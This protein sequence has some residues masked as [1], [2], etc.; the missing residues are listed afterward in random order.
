MEF[1]NRAKAVRL[2]SQHNKFL[3]A[4]NDEEGVKQTRNGSSKAARWA[5]EPVEGKPNL[6]RLKSCES[7]KYLSATDEPFLLGMTGKKVL[8][9]SPRARSDP[10][11]EWEPLKDGSFVRLRTRKGHFLRANGGIPPWMNSVTHDVPSRSST[12]DWVLW[13]V[14]IL[15]VDYQSGPLVVEEDDHHGVGVNQTVVMSEVDDDQGLSRNSSYSSSSSNYGVKMERD[16]SYDQIGSPARSVKSSMENPEPSPRASPKS[17]AGVSPLMQHHLRQE[18]QHSNSFKQL[19]SMLDGI[20]N[21]LDDDNVVDTKSDVDSR[22]SS[23]DSTSRPHSLDVKMAKQILKELKNMNFS[24]IL[25]TEREKKLEKAVNILVSDAKTSTLGQ[26]PKDLI[27]LQD[28][29][30]SMKNDHESAAQDLVECTTFST[31]K[32]ETRAELKKD[33]AKAHEL[34]YMEVGFT[35]MLATSR[36]K[37]EELLRQLEEIDNSI[38]AAERAQA[39]NAVE[40]EELISRIGERSESLREMEKQEK[41]LQARKVEAE[42]TLERV[43]EEWV[44]VKSLFQDV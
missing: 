10:S 3:T 6:I 15:E 20:H 8:Q 43:E 28:R 27:Y 29:L 21:L 25:S 1:F 40:I 34:E 4:S 9:V 2:R 35:N 36:A 38:R 12:Q 18:S 5:V 17:S 37:R 30:K 32:I 42:R 16:D 39:D 41:T 11:V 23:M 31:R 19:K 14:D 22:R 33:A 13:M 7:W 24:D 26:V 44:Q